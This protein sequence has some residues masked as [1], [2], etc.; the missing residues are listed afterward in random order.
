MRSLSS[1]LPLLYRRWGEYLREISSSS[2]NGFRH[3]VQA[4]AHQ[5]RQNIITYA[6]QQLEEYTNAPAYWTR[7]VQAYINSLK[8]PADAFAPADLN[9]PFQD[10]WVIFQ[11]LVHQYAT[12]LTHWEGI[13]NALT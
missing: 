3:L 10:R 1:A 6:Q 4:N 13:F 5:T 11:D 8:K 12:L 7:G 9:G 2:P